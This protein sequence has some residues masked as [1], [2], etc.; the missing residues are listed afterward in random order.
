MN[1]RRLRWS[2]ERYRKSA[3]GRLS[4][5]LAKPRSSSGA[6]LWTSFLNRIRE[7]G[8]PPYCSLGSLVLQRRYTLQPSCGSHWS[9]TEEQ[10]DPTSCDEHAWRPESGTLASAPGHAGAPHVRHHSATAPSEPPPPS[11]RPPQ[12]RQQA[13]TM[14]SD[15][16]IMSPRTITRRC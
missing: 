6:R 16:R 14:I 1:P 7:I 2:P 10:A 12:A 5:S 13:T 8:Q 9:P 3:S 15:L 4:K 11:A